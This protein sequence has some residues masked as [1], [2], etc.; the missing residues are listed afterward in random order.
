MEN[1]FFPVFINLNKKKCLV[2][3]GGKI[4]CRKIKTLL[5]YG[6]EVKV[7]SKSIEK[8][9]ISELN[10]EIDI[11]D[12]K[13]GDVDGYFLIVAA[14]DNHELNREIFL[15]ADSKGILVNNMTT[16]V[17]LN[18]RFSAILE[19]DDFTVA[20]SS[21]GRSPKQAVEIRDRLEEYFEFIKQ[22]NKKN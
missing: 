12:Y 20:I 2:V 11:R 5:K 1:D 8:K 16:K 3:G 21:K 19:R 18:T 14:T 10:L 17:D 15:E 22:N 6:A 13:A 9:E 4:A 7:I